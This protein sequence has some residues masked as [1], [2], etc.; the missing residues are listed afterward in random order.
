MAEMST[1]KRSYLAMLLSIVP[2]MG[3]LY[4]RKPLKGLILFLGVSSAG[5]VIYISSLPVNDWRDLVRFDGLETWWK[6]RQAG[7]ESRENAGKSE[8]T[9]VKA[10]EYHERDYHLYT[11]DDNF[12]FRIDAQFQRHLDRKSISE[13]L[14]RIFKDNNILLSKEAIVSIKKPNTRW[15]ISDGNRTYAV[16]KVDGQLNIFAVKN[17]M[18]R[19]SWKL[20]ISGFIQ[21]I[22]FWI[23]AVF[24]SWKGRRGF[25]RRALK[26]KLKK[27]ERDSVEESE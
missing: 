9:A 7:I 24:D 25:N 6:S 21:G 11:F 27:T 20:K 3:Q 2:G 22:A 17:L 10:K 13:K 19:P 18:Y 23:Y 4:L 15:I 5:A 16:R 1:V 14:L 12:L 26:K 8:P